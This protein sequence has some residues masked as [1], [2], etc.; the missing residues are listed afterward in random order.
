MPDRV[1]LKWMARGFLATALLLAFVVYPRIARSQAGGNAAEHL[2]ASVD[3]GEGRTDDPLGRRFVAIV[4]PDVPL[5]NL[6]APAGDVATDTGRTDDPLGRVRVPLA[7]DDGVNSNLDAASPTEASAVLLSPDAE[8]ER[9]AVAGP[10][11]VYTSPLVIPAADFRADGFDPD[12]IF[13]SFGGGYWTGNAA[14][15]GCLIAPAY[16]PAGVTV[17]DMFVS[18]YDNDSSRDIGVNLR[19]VD[20]FTGTVTPMA[21]ATT[22][23]SFVGVQT[24]SDSSITTPVILYPDYSYYVTTC[25][26]SSSLRLYSV[27]LY[28]ATP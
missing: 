14:V 8:A 22:A 26:G 25:L 2:A 23:G 16:L 15:Y 4:E 1:T 27:R 17:T 3:A 20:N 28:Y 13:F 6:E 5:S 12:S 9:Q 19:R 18:V 7:A 10:E 21:S 11:A 24:I